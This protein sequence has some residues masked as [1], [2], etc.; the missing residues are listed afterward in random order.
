MNDFD[1]SIYAYPAMN[2]YPIHTKEAAL[3]SY[4]Q[5][6]REKDKV[7][8]LK[9]DEIEKVFQ[10]AAS[11]YE[12]DLTPQEKTD[13]APRPTVQCDAG[14]G[15]VISMNKIASVEDVEA[16]TKFILDKRATMKRKQL[17]QAA[18][19]VLWCAASSDM[20]MNTPELQK[21][22]HIAGIG[23][24][25]RQEI[26][27]E[28]EKRATLNIF[29]GK[30]K[31]AFWEYTKN[32][33]AMSDAD[34]YKEATL[35]DLCDCIEDIDELYGNQVKYGSTLKAPEDVC[36]AQTMDDLLKEA[37]DLA[38]I[39]SID[40]TISKKALLERADAANS[41]FKQHFGTGEK[42][43]NEALVQKVASLDA[44]TAEALLDAIE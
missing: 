33:K 34:F 6:L 21:I 13:A 12:I 9:A 10:K 42:L 4:A 37:S 17:K 8:E 20:D 24:G 36:F 27:H 38:Y 25:D 31:E 22:A 39:E 32:V 15:Q 14:D 30:D 41:F 28:L 26:E 29:S 18:K 43:E 44:P 11:Y 16:A 1:S 7:S 2:K 35:N 5:F 19:Y 3:N 40:T 23:V